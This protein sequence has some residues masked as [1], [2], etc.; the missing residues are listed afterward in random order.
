[1]EKYEFVPKG[2]CCRKM[3]VSVDNG[4][5]RDVEFIGGCPGNTLGIASL[6]KGMKIEEVVSKLDGIK[7]GFKKTSCPNELAKFLKDIK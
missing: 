1:M 5:V 6:I 7:C 4:I 3:V 2:V